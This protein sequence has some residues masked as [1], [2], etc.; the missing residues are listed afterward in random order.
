LRGGEEPLLSKKKEKFPE[1]VF[2]G[3][4]TNGR[5]KKKGDRILRPGQSEAFIGNKQLMRVKERS[6]GE[7]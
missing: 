7:N 1:G 5:G 2:Q 6:Q 3:A 4:E